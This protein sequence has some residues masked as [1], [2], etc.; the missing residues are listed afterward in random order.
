[1]QMYIR[2][3]LTYSQIFF[4]DFSDPEKQGVREKA[5]KFGGKGGNQQ[6][7]LRSKQASKQTNTN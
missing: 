6:S 3:M 2:R 7:D 4:R 1:M 5:M